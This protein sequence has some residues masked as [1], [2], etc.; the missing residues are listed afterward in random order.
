MYLSR[1]EIDTGNRQKIQDLTHLGAYH[2]WVEDSFPEEKKS[3]ER[4]RKLWRLDHLY[5][6]IWLL[7]QSEKKPDL[8]SLE[9]YGVKN[10]AETKDY[11]PFL[12][13]LENGEPYRF[14]V[15]INPVHSVSQGLGLRGKV[16]P[17]ITE[18]KQLEYLEKRADKYGFSLLENQY[19]IT[20]RSFE[21][22]KKNQEK[23]L[24]LCRVTVEGKLVVT[25]VGL[26]RD[27]LVKGIGRKKAYGFGL[28]TVIPYMK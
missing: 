7:V 22:L 23:P 12:Q 26:F 2:S 14:K 16:Y 19:Q 4:S 5:G 24:R 27:S 1:V 18:N 20:D 15:V 17:E 3:G 13:K 28:M 9:K 21:L 10:S 11:T 25:N 8:M 6:K